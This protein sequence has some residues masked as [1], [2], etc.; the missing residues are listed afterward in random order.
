MQ[1]YIA[2]I[3]LAVI[4]ICT[5][6][7][8]RRLKKQSIQSV[9]IRKGKKRGF[10]RVFFTVWF[11]Y[12]VSAF[13]LNLPH[14]DYELLPWNATKWI[15]VNFC[16]LAL[17][18]Y[19]AGLFALGDSFRIGIDPGE[20]GTLVQNGLYAFCRNPMSFARILLFLGVFLVFPDVIFL[21]FA[22]FGIIRTCKQVRREEEALREKHGEAY[23]A[24]CKRSHR[25]C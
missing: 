21:L 12:R 13:A 11:A 14:M 8:M 16:L 7:Q 4:G 9:H 15:G 25:F 17:A 23:E 2:F 6:V 19:L 5:L 20:G 22:F 3:A 18:L 1:K 10:W 24:Y